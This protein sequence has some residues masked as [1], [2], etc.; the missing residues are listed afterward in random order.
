MHKLNHIFHTRPVALVC[1]VGL[2]FLALS[3]II[4]INPALEMQRA[5]RVANAGNIVPAEDVQRG[6]QIYIS[7]GCGYCHSQ[8][9][10]PTLVDVNYGRASAATDYVGQHPPMPGTQRTGPDLSNVGS[11][12]P[13]W[14][15]QFM[16]LYN[17][18]S[19]VPDSLMPSYPWYFE[20]TTLEQAK[21]HEFGDY[22]SAFPA[23]ILADGLVAVP[24][25]TAVDLI[26][27]LRSLKQE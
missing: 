4:M 9:V 20:V 14:M 19:M 15:W 12:Q 13:S 16:H 26:S 21:T 1:I 2:I 22:A 25:Q 27:Y 5:T 23:E 11:R 24:T 10:R 7:E 18:R 17:P 8:F 6:R 3:W